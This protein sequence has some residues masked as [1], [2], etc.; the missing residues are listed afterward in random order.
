MVNIMHYARLD[1]YGNVS[2]TLNDHL[3]GVAKGMDIG[4]FEISFSHFDSFML[5]EVVKYTGYFHDLGKFTDYFQDYL[6]NG[7]ESPYSDHAHISAV[8]LY[9]TLRRKLKI[10]HFKEVNNVLAFF[11]YICVGQ[12]HGNLDMNRYCQK[13][14]FVNALE[15]LQTQADNLLKKSQEIFQEGPFPA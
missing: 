2:Q 1:K 8:C 12:H 7:K 14:Y 11:L 3:N 6:I 13:K 9:L 15:K 4:L 10:D 5:K